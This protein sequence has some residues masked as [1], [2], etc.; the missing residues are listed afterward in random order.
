MPI[1]IRIPIGETLRVKYQLQATDESF[2]FF[3]IV[4][5]V[6]VDMEPPKVAC[7]SPNVRSIFTQPGTC[8][9]L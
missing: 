7:P 2:G 8:N 5:F 3:T 1:P 9:T 6:A 4:S